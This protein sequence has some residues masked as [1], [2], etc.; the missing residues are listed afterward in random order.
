MERPTRSD[1]HDGTV[2]RATAPRRR[3][4]ASGTRAPPTPPRPPATTVA[5]QPFPTARPSPTGFA[6]PPPRRTTLRTAHGRVVAVASLLVAACACRPHGLPNARR[7]AGQATIEA[8]ITLARGRAWDGRL[9]FVPARVG[10]R[11][12]RLLLDTGANVP[13]LTLATAESAGLD[14]RPWNRT[15]EDV[16]GQPVSVRLLSRGALHV[17]GRPLEPAFAVSSPVLDAAGIAGAVPPGSLAPPG[18]YVVV[19]FVERRVRVV[20]GSLPRTSP[21][22]E[23]LEGTCPVY[24]PREQRQWTVRVRIDGRPAR[25]FVDTGSATTT[26]HEDTAIGRHLASLIGGNATRYRIAGVGGYA[27][28]RAVPDVP[29]RI[30]GRTI[31]TAVGIVAPAAPFD[32]TCAADGIVGFDILKR[33]RLTFSGHHGR[34]ACTS[35]P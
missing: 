35:A 7:G 24:D 28:A 8:P 12:L 30:A 32:E 9:P 14:T 20:R 18:T 15:A 11:T 4:R 2:Y 6:V 26:V 23:R 31:E 16:G 29:V 13:F 5:P 1:H 19:D 25:L 17:L 10:G 34:I 21:R 27:T 22:S 3:F 33:C